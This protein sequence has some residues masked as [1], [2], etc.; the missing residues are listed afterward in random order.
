MLKLAK[1]HRDARATIIT[2]TEVNPELCGPEIFYT[3]SF[4]VE[5]FFFR[6]LKIS[7]LDKLSTNFADVVFGGVNY[8]K[9]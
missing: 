9:D 6:L 8:R 7:R 5:D 4:S 1:L 3:L 2:Q